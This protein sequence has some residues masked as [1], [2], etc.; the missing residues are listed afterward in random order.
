V[1][2]DSKQAEKEVPSEPIVII[3]PSF[4][5]ICGDN[6]ACRATIFNQLLYSIAWKLKQGYRYWYATAEEICAAVDHSW[7]V[8]KV[9][10]E[11]DALVKAGLLGQQHNGERKWDRT[12]QYFFGEEQGQKLKAICKKVGI[13]LLHIGLPKDVLHLLKMVHAID[14]EADDE[15]TECTCQKER[16]MHLPNMGNASTINGKSKYQKGDIE[17]PHMGHRSTKNGGAI[18]KEPSKELFLETDT[19]EQGKEQETWRSRERKTDELPQPDYSLPSLPSQSE[20]IKPL[21]TVAMPPTDP[22]ITGVFRIEDLTSE[23]PHSWQ[24]IMAIGAHYLGRGKCTQADAEALASKTQVLAG[25]VGAHEARKQI[26][27]N[28]TFMI[29][30]EA[31]SNWYRDKRN[32]VTLRAAAT[33]HEDYSRKA[34][35][36]QWEPPADKVPAWFNESPAED[37]EAEELPSVGMTWSVAEALVASIQARYPGLHLSYEEISS[38]LYTVNLYPASRRSWPL[39]N[40]EEWHHPNAR[41]QAKIAQAIEQWQRSRELEVA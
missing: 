41:G 37:V 29:Y 3:R 26:I 36:V 31:P 15:Q 4:K 18:P 22:N 11:V 40:A 39:F 38:E 30:S 9:R 33:Y 23:M 19:E 7:C 2:T 1:S 6:D 14:E 12:F 34:Q 35:E 20:M 5:K 24:A 21:T 27:T 28:I 32:Q 10:K 13:C 16:Q 25:L 17:S 8:N